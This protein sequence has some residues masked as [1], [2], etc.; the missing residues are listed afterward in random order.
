MK[1]VTTTVE[2]KIIFKI[3]HFS[4]NFVQYRLQKFYI[5]EK[6]NLEFGECFV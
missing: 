4:I 2:I 1:G 6:S 5:I 3:L